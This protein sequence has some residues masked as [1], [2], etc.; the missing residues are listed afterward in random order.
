M[1]WIATLLVLILIILS[2]L[3]FAPL[4]VEVDS[5]AGS[6]RVRFHKSVSAK[7]FIHESSLFIDLRI[8]RWHKMIDLVAL[9]KKWAKSE[10]RKAGRKK[11][12]VSLRKMWAIFRSFKVSRFYLTVD[13]G[14]MQM[15][16]ILYPVFIM[17]GRRTGGNIS[18]NF[19]DENEIIFKANNNLF[20]ILRV[21][22]IS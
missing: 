11:R 1:S 21:Y 14:S 8:L 18:I 6:F 19:T 17:A 13:T 4:C 2:Y 10:G 20:R 16:G 7:L 15:N 22:F 5:T 12:R 3:L 9:R